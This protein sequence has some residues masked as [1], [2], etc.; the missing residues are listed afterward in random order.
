M[1]PNIFKFLQIFATLIFTYCEPERTLSRLKIIQTYTVCIHCISNSI[2]QLRLNGLTSLNI[3]HEVDV[4]VEK[5]IQTM[6]FKRRILLIIT[7]I[8]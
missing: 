8:M 5:L 1:L 3:H 6:S 2:G 7:D 4:T